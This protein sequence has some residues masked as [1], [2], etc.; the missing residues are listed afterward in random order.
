M[1]DWTYAVMWFHCVLYMYRLM[2]THIKSLNRRF[3]LSLSS[4]LPIW[5]WF[6]L[7]SRFFRYLFEFAA[8]MCF[9]IYC[10][11]DKTTPYLS[12]CYC[13]RYR[14]HFNRKSEMFCWFM[15]GD[16]ASLSRF[17][18]VARALHAHI[19]LLWGELFR[20]GFVEIKTSLSVH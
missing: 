18:R 14:Y 19:Y 17:G 1:N 5:S 7:I 12:C 3:S 8:M 16:G 13:Y 10:C 2:T 20:S 6:A 15:L 11:Y 4:F 9:I